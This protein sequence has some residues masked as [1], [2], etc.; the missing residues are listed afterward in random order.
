MR[1]FYIGN[2]KWFPQLPPL[3]A[4]GV[5]TPKESHLIISFCRQQQIPLIIGSNANH[6]YKQIKALGPDLIIVTGHPFLLKQ[7]LLSLC[8]AI[9]FHP[10][11]LPKRRG[12][13]PLNWAIIDG[14]TE[15]GV[16]TFW[17]TSGI[18]S[19]AI[20]YQRKLPI[21]PIDTAQDLIVNTNRILKIMFKNIIR[22][23]PRLPSQ[24]QDES[25]ATYTKKRIPADSEITLNMSAVMI[26]RIVRASTGPYPSAYIRNKKGEKIYINKVS[27]NDQ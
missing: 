13:A 14:L 10:S 26:D 23:Y 24:K 22:R 1:I 15:T 19:G 11:L 5:F 12:R 27:I 2:D 25:K 9:G 20:I 16:T 6:A 8:P 4:C 3:E 7:P 17:I 21:R 18:D